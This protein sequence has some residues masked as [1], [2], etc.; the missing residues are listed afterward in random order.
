MYRVAGGGVGYVQGSRGGFR[1]CT[2]QQG[3]GVGYVQGRGGGRACTGQQGE[4]L[5]HV[6]GSRERI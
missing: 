2:G 3:G 4:G 6:Q 1:A 5:G